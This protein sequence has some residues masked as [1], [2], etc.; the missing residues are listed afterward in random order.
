MKMKYGDLIYFN[1]MINE[2]VSIFIGD[3][4]VVENLTIISIDTEGVFPPYNHSVSAFTGYCLGIDYESF[5]PFSPNHSLCCFIKHREMQVPI[6]IDSFE[7]KMADMG[8]G[9]IIRLDGGWVVYP[10]GWHSAIQVCGHFDS[11]DFLE[12]EKVKIKDKKIESRF[13]ILDL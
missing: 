9:G 8:E 13:E 3:K 12:E 10:F 7:V 6:Y 2:N 11:R 5:L 1:S 4:E